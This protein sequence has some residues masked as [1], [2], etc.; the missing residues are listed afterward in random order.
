[1]KELKSFIR[2][3]PDFPTP[4]IN[5]KDITPLLQDKYAFKRAID[6]LA[7]ES[8]KYSFD[9]ILAIESRGFFFG[10]A[11]SYKMGLGFVPV[12]KKG[13]LPYKKVSYTYS[14][15][16]GHDTL[17]MHED[18]VKEGERVLIVDDLLATGGT[19]NAVINMVEKLKGIVSAAAFLIELDFLE[20]R[21]KLK[22]YPIISLIHY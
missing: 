20:G 19:V 6:M 3:I 10:G 17:E 21:E 4:C 11:L 22:S 15:E 12:R 2:E 14:L 1:M 9:K 16:Y 7:C 18:A 8:A 13:K 5:F